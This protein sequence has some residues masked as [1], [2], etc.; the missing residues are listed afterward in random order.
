MKLNE[1]ETRILVIAVLVVCIAF[2]TLASVSYFTN[3]GHHT[4]PM[5][6]DPTEVVADSTS[7]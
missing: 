2:I 6:D 4:S 5:A 7:H 1:M 3:G